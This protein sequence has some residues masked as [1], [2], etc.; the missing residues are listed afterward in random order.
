MDE[1]TDVLLISILAIPFVIAIQAWVKKR[2]D[3]RRNEEGE[4][5]FKTTREAL[6]A[7]LLE[8]LAIVGG[9]AILIAATSGILRYVINTYS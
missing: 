3:S 2:K 8:G 6:F 5:E 9:L 4:E 1:S 7:F